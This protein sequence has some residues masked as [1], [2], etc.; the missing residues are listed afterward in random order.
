[1]QQKKQMDTLITTSR[2]IIAIRPAQEADAQAFRD[3]RLEALHNHPEAF[4]ADYAANYEHPSTFWTERLHSPGNEGM[5]YFVI[6]NDGLIGMC[7]IHRGN[8]PKEQHSANYLGSICPIRMA[9][10][11][12]R[13]RIDNSMH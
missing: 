8:S 3:L 10:L 12:D 2:G 1:M 11:A 7:G 6:H 9:R 5:I 4:S 13:R